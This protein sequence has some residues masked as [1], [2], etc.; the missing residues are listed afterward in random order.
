LDEDAT[1]EPV[2]GHQE[3]PHR[4]VVAG[5]LGE[6]EER[7]DERAVAR[8]L[9]AVVD[10]GQQRLSREGAAVAFPSFGARL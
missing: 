7:F 9:A 10:L 6:L 1:R 4:L 3:P 5:R 8:P 2:E